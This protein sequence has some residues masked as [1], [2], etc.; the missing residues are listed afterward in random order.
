[1]EGTNVG[2]TNLSGSFTASAGTVATINT[3]TGYSANDL[4][5]TQYT[6]RMEVTSKHRNY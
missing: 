6:L 1:M 5:G 4:K 2:I 3:L